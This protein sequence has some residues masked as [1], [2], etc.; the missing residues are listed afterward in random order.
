MKDESRFYYDRAYLAIE[1]L[2]SLDEG[3]EEY[4]YDSAMNDLNNA[5]A[6][7]P[8]PLY[9][10]TRGHHFMWDTEYDAAEYDFSVA[11]ALE[12]ESAGLYR[13]RAFAR[14][15]Q[16]DY[17]GALA[18]LTEAIRLEPDNAWHY[19]SRADAHAHL[20]LNDETETD[21]KAALELDP[22]L[23]E[24][25]ERLKREIAGWNEPLEE[26]LS[27]EES[28]APPYPQEEALDDDMPF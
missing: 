2:E 3:D 23:S 1:R 22:D 4:L 24:E 15:G 14:E 9:Y 10:W 8:D 25:V 27:E 21:F 20:L 5:I 12:P 7:K 11:I 17:H 6:L 18:D 13:S 16:G 19:L 26:E 28:E